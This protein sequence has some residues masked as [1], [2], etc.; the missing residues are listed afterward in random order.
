MPRSWLFTRTYVNCLCDFRARGGVNY[1]D[2]RAFTPDGVRYDAR[3]SVF[4]WLAVRS[5]R[6][7]SGISLADDVIAAWHD[8]EQRLFSW[9]CRRSRESVV[10]I[11][12]TLTFRMKAGFSWP[13]A[14]GTAFASSRDFNI[15]FVV[16]AGL[17]GSGLRN[18]VISYLSVGVSHTSL[19]SA[20]MPQLYQPVL[21]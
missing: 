2:S 21:S 8:S 5:R 16:V 14:S 20:R 15:V 3:L 10:R 1:L 4:G 18:G 13:M 9:A 19:R 7:K 6:H 12:R 11:G 17:W